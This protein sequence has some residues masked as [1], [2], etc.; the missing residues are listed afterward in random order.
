MYVKTEHIEE[1]IRYYAIGMSEEEICDLMGLNCDV[2]VEILDTY[3]KY[4]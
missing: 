2:V 4:L 3:T 1:V